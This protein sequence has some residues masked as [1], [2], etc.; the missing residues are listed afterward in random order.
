MP[1]SMM[2]PLISY[3][4][5]YG[6]PETSRAG[7]DT[8][9]TMLER[10]CGFAAAAPLAKEDSFNISQA[11]F[12]SFFIPFGL[13]RLVIVDAGNPMHGLVVVMCKMLGIPHMTVAKGNHRAI[14]NE[15]C[16]RYLNKALKIM[17]AD[18]RSTKAWCRRCC[19]RC[20]P[21]MHRQSM[22]QT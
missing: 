18:L 22:A 15:R 12:R 4:L 10:I 9:L 17:V 19:L 2:N 5:M 8:C 3:S 13:P 16:H 21:G 7:L 14:R 1:M 6:H 20:I 11:T